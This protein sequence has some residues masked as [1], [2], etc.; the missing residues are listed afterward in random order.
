VNATTVRLSVT[1]LFLANLACVAEMRAQVGTPPTRKDQRKEMRA[2]PP[3]SVLYDQLMHPDPKSR[4][5]ADEQRMDALDVLGIGGNS[6]EEIR[7]TYDDLNGDHTPEALF[8]IQVAPD[9][10]NLVVLKQKGN[11]WYRLASPDEFSCYCKYGALPLVEF[12]K[13][14]RWAY[15]ESEPAKLLSVTQSAGGTGLYMRDRFV[16]S[17]QGF[18]LKKVFSVKEELRDCTRW[19]EKNVSCDLNHEE[20][21]EV[22]APDQPH[23]LLAVSYQRKDVAGEFWDDTWWI[24]LPIQ[25]CKAYTWNA[26]RQQF[27]ENPKATAAY[28]GHL[29]SLFPAVRR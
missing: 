15:Y 8:T 11:Q 17:L 21:Q 7:L 18:E 22:D 1:L 25:T 3:P 4:F 5:S 23:A 2:S 14:E 28:C 9:D 26:P 13:I 10:V 29:G 16:F 20:I 6:F 19:L 27:S 24:G 12:A